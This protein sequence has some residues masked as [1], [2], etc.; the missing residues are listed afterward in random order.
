MPDTEVLDLLHLVEL[1][2]QCR[3]IFFDMFHQT[4]NVL[5]DD[6]V[7]I[8]EEIRE[9]PGRRCLLTHPEVL[10]RDP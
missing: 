8:S 7:G 1:R 5:V 4:V 6:L 10:I 2:K 9:S 3:V